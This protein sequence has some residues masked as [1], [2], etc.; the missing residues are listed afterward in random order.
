MLPIASRPV[1]LEDLCILHQPQPISPRHMALVHEHG[2]VVGVVANT[3]EEDPPAQEADLQGRY[4]DIC[5]I[6]VPSVGADAVG[7]DGVEEL[8]EVQE[9]EQGE[10][11]ADEQLN[12]EDPV[13]AALRDKR[14]DAEPAA[15]VHDAVS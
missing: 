9:E 15:M 5:A 10:D 2:D 7:Y 14:L 11:A 13:E 4:V 12:Q 1:M 6:F 8:V 3:L